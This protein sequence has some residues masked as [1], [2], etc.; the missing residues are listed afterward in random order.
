LI[1][2]SAGAGIIDPR[3]GPL[4]ENGGPTRTHAL[5]AGSPAIDR[6]PFTAPPSPVRDYQLN[7]SLADALGG[8]S[9]VALG[10]STTATGYRFGPNQGLNLSTAL[11]NPGHYS[12]E[13]VFRWDALS[14]GWQKIIDFH[15]LATNVGLYTASNGLHFL[16]GAFTANLFEPNV[17][18]RLVI[19]RDDATDT[20]RAYVDGV[21]AWSFTDAAGDAV[22]DGPNQ[23]IRFFQDDTVTNQTEAQAGFVDLIRFY[24]SVLTAEQVVDLPDPIVVPNCDQRGEPFARVRDGDGMS[25]AQIDMGAYERQEPLP[26]IVPGD[27]NANG[28]VDAADFV[29]W[30]KAVGLSVPPFS[31]ADG[32]G[33]GVVDQA[34]YDVWRAN[35]GRSTPA[36]A[37]V[38]MARPS[39]SRP[40]RRD[41]LVAPARYDDA[42]LAWLASRTVGTRHELAAIAF[43]HS[44]NE[45]DRQESACRSRDALD[46][47]FGYLATMA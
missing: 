39:R 31:G 3:L 1:G 19:T 7:G 25:G 12:I 14:G 28:I 34:D 29:V 46:R 20:V 2:S 44:P 30:R 8:P 40:A 47:A 33:N 11:A 45:V 4:A 18:R 9:L 15:N 24:N 10:G 32:S 43:G 6:I 13:L 16:N 37:V 41:S 21:E 36:D 42:L 35:F 23:I 38:E 22:F 17:A 26:V 27:Y 5:L